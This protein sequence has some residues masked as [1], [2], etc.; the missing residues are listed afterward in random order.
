MKLS[1]LHTALLHT[2]ADSNQLYLLHSCNNETQ[3]LIIIIDYPCQQHTQIMRQY[4]Y[5]P[6]RLIRPNV[7]SILY[8]C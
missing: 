6:S 2:A 5:F 8:S 1:L 7:L 4:I 3:C